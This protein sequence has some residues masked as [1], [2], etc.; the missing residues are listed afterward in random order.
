MRVLSRKTL[1]DCW[2]PHP[3]AE[4]PLRR[5]FK[6]AEA[7]SWSGPSDIK[8]VY[9]SASFVGTDRVVFNIGGNSYRLIVR[10]DY[11]YK[12]LFVRFVGTHREY[13]DVNA[14]EV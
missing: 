1:Q 13:D 7:A 14:A 12:I 5:W 2:K 11:K 3:P 9:A 10:I 4:E 6:E 8:A